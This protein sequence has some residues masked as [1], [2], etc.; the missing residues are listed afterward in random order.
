MSIRDALTLF[1]SARRY[2]ASIQA[3]A[4]VTDPSSLPFT[5]PWATSDLARIVAE[6]VFGTTAAAN[7]RSSAMRLPP[8]ARARNLT[9]TTIARMPLRSQV[10]ETPTPTQPAFLARAGNGQSPQLRMTWTVD[11]LIFY[12]WSCWWRDNDPATG[13]IATASR[14]GQDEWGTNGDGKLEVNGVEVKPN[15]VIVIPGLH[16]GILS[17][18]VESLDDAR[19]LYRNVRQR[20]QNPVAQVDL[21]QTG[22]PQLSPVEVDELLAR[23]TKARQGG[24]GGVS[25]TP[26]SITPNEMGAGADAQL[27][28]EARN[29]A[30]VDLARIVGVHAGLID[31]TAPKAS[32][33]Y[34]TTTGRNQEFVDF[35][36]A[37]Y[38]T[39]IT[40][41]LSLDD[42]LPPGEHASFDL[43]DFT[44]LA[45]SV[46]GPNLE[47]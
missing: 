36:L 18:G 13:A 44:S 40:A 10:G 5:S 11:D 37:L 45:P 17:Y 20:L 41:R 26:E 24:N 46:T 47:D 31:A 34:E 25:Y 35:D 3:A 8:I 2:E 29:A 39:P 32:L 22:G 43:T 38:M 19:A 9:C 21:H 15:D 7:T 4:S 1:S 16:E 42:V 12:G 14:L 28:I 6:D 23:W 27:M 33:N 30:A